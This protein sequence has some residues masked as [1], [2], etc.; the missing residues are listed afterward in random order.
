MSVY[1]LLL[2]TPGFQTSPLGS[3]WAHHWH[4]H[5]GRCCGHMRCSSSTAAQL[6]CAWT[7]SGRRGNIPT[8][9]QPWKGNKPSRTHQQPTGGSSAWCTL[10]QQT[11][12][13]DLQINK[14]LSISL[15]LQKVFRMKQG[16]QVNYS[17]MKQNFLPTL[18]SALKQ[19]C[20]QL[21]RKLP[22]HWRRP[23]EHCY[24]VAS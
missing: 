4:G 24:F 9:V 10:L 13:R 1:T 14:H 15:W 19:I 5:S 3:G 12:E 21:I 8:A 6:W 17:Q 18:Y 20:S 23:V 16:L 2:S 11:R 22:K 7:P